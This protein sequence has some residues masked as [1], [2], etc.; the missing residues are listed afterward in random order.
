[1]TKQ[2]LRVKKARN[3]R[4]K[5]PIATQMNL[6]TI[7]ENLW[8]M[9][10]ECSDVRYFF[11][12]SEDPETLLGELL[13]DEDEAYEFRMMFSDLSAECDQFLDD[14]GNWEWSD[15]LEEYFDF[16]MVLGDQTGHFAG[17]DVYG[18]DEFG[19]GLSYEEE[20]AVEAGHEKRKKGLTT[21]ERLERFTTGR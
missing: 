4:Y 12:D 9:Q 19:L 20:A 5:K 17:D 14:L 8:E 13:G 3:L 18:D 7:K 11:D 10:S 2:E 16:F 15:Y 21:D 1:M 6:E